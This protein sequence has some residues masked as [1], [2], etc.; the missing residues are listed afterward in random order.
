M[1]LLAFEAAGPGVSVALAAGAGEDVPDVVGFRRDLEPGA[2]DRLLAH[3]AD[4][5]QA[6]R[7]EVGAL[8][9]VV[10]DRGP[11]SFTGIRT[12]VAAARG[13]ALAS[14]RPLYAFSRLELL[15]ATAEPGDGILAVVVRVGRERVLVQAFDAGRRALD[16]PRLERPASA[17]DGLDRPLH[18]VGSGVELVVGSV[19]PAEV[20]VGRAQE[21]DAVTLIALAH[22]RA[23]AGL[24][25]VRPF[26]LEPMYPRPPDAVPPRRLIE[27]GDDP[28]PAHARAQA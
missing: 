7:L 11:G 21:V 10:V 2:G 4:L 12:A 8:D 19:A 27:R 15:A 3:V 25:P 9:G 23:P 18:V 1:R 26:E 28:L 20:R 17:L 22:A 5:L 14:A 16:A 6:A 24:A 13:L